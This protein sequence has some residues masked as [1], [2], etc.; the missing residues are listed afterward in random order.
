MTVWHDTIAVFGDNDVVLSA[1]VLTTC[2]HKALRRAAICQWCW[3]KQDDS[4][5]ASLPAKSSQPVGCW[6]TQ[7]QR[8]VQGLP[9][10]TSRAAEHQI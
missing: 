9:F 2:V 10:L 8:T 3:H 6:V 5:R 7:V 1:I 4:L